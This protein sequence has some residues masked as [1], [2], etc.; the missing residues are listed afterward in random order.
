M[1]D[2][3]KKDLRA[4]NSCQAWQ[5]AARK[6]NDIDETM[7]TLKQ[8]I[9][10][11]RKLTKTGYPDWM[12]EEDYMFCFKEFLQQKQQNAKDRYASGAAFCHA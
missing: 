5:K 6:H 11:R 9:E 7:T 8:I 1:K 2:L 10:E 4:K 12:T 3:D